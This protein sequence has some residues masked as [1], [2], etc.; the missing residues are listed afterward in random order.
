MTL[1]IPEYLAALNA[2]RDQHLLDWDSPAD[3]LYVKT[4]G[5]LR[6]Q[7]QVYPG[8]GALWSIRHERAGQLT[9]GSSESYSVAQI[10]MLKYAEHWVRTAMVGV[11]Q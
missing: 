9:H 4:V 7:V 1:K 8:Q 6:L 11:L 3:N 10:E 5:K 2:A